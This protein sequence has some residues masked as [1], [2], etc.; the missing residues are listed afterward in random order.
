MKINTKKIVLS[1]PPGLYEALKGLAAEQGHT[2]PGY[3]RRLL[4]RH[5]DEKG[6]PVS[7][8]SGEGRG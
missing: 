4:W 3:I 5:V 1:V 2:V 8:F 7:I 6:I